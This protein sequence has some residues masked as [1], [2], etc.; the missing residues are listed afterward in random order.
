MP[1]IDETQ[2]RVID[3]LVSYKVR[4]IEALKQRNP[5]LE[6]MTLREAT[7]A[8]MEIINKEA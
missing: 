6:F 2:E 8:I 7:K 4:E 1:Y 3:I 5:K